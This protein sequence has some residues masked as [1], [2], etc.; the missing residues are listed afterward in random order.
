MCGFLPCSVG[1]AP[2]NDSPARLNNGFIQ[3]QVPHL[4][5]TGASHRGT[6]IRRAISQ[7]NSN[8][9]GK[10]TWFLQIFP[11]KKPCKTWWLQGGLFLPSA[12]AQGGENPRTH[13]APSL[14]SSS[15]P[16]WIYEA[17]FHLLKFYSHSFHSH[18]VK[19]GV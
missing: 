17:A 11:V 2:D 19:S 14:A 4:C 5:H 13:R 3:S 9:E 12:L 7:K 6:A 16:L 15:L 1:A 10:K 18:P 8:S